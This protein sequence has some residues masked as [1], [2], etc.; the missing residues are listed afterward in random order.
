M[1][2]YLI[3]DTHFGYRQ[4]S[5]S[6]FE[7]QMKFMKTFL[8]LLKKK[9]GRVFHLGDVFHSREFVPVKIG[10]EVR[11]LFNEIEKYSTEFYIISGNHDIYSPV[12]DDYTSIEMVLD[13]PV[14][15]REV[16]ELDDCIL[17]PWSKT[18]EIEM[19]Y[20]KGKPILTHTD[21]LSMNMPKV[22]VISGHLHQRF[23]EGNKINLGSCFA[24]N[25]GDGQASCSADGLASRF[26]DSPG[27]YIYTTEDF[28]TF[29]SIENTDSIRFLRVTPDTL[30]QA[31]PGDELELYIQRSELTKTVED[32]IKSLPN[33]IKIIYVQEQVTFSSCHCDIY[34][35]IDGCIPDHLKT[36]YDETKEITK[37]SLHR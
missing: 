12:S 6:F 13:Q 10:E 7:S 35:I 30:D 3:T 26:A 17:V 19:L 20:G 21:L 8:K 16:V 24:F 4:A 1:V 18:G 34:S 33:K 25:F 31:R 22:P 36:I 5:P 14:I 15:V 11:K 29:T 32:Y 37:S 2:S 9:P 23:F 27:K 28:K